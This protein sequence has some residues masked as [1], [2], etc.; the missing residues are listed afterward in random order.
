[1]G[2]PEIVKLGGKTKLELR[3]LL[4]QGG[5]QLNAY[6]EELFASDLFAVSAAPRAVRITA[7]PVESLGFAEGA[8]MSDI[9]PKAAELGLVPCPLELGPYLRL[10]YQDQPESGDAQLSG[11][12]RA[13]DGS[14]TVVSEPLTSDEAFPKGFYL[15]RVNGA[16]WL[17][18]YRCG[19]DHIWSPQDNLVFAA[20]R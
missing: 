6:A 15:R 5:V 14:V 13:P 1:M 11:G 7:V 9:L 4:R 16:L 17:R 20:T 12:G 8:V 2:M 18:A 10:Q 3:A 19:P